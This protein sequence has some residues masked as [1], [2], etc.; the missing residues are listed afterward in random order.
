MA[1]PAHPP[2]II[3][4]GL[5]E[6]DAANGELRKAGVPVKIHPQPFRVL[7]LLAQRPGEVV[8]REEIRRSLWGDNTFVDFERGINFCVNQIRA[9][10][11]DD[12]EKPRFVET[13]PRR[14]YR[15]IASVSNQLLVDSTHARVSVEISSLPRRDADEPG[16]G[17]PRLP[18]LR[19]VPKPRKV[20]QRLKSAYVGAVSLAGI[21]GLAF[22]YYWFIRRLPLSLRKPEATQLTANSS[23]NPVTSSAISPDGKYLAFTDHMKK[24]R[25]RLLKTGETRT[26]PE[27]E[28]LKGSFVDWHVASW[29]PDGTRFLVNASTSKTVAKSPGSKHFNPPVTPVAQESSIWSVSLLGGA[30]GK[31]RDDA[32][33]YSVSPDGS[34]IAFETNA[35]ELGTR[36]IRLMNVNG[37]QERMLCETDR[38]STI[39][40]ITWSRDGRRVI[41][42]SFNSLQSAII[43]HD[44]QGGAP[45]T[46]ASFSRPNDLIDSI[47]SPDGRLIYVLA[48][49]SSH[50]SCNFWELAVNSDTGRATGK[51]RQLSNWSGSCIGQ[52]SMTTDGKQLAFHRW[53]RQTAVYVAD[54][55]GSGMVAGSMRRLTRSE[56]VNAAETW[57]PD[58]KALVFRSLRDGHLKIFRQALDSDTEEMLVVGAE[59]AGGTSISPDGSWLFYLDCGKKWDCEHTVPLMRIPISGGTPQLVLQSNTYGRPRCAVSPATLCAIAESSDDGKS[60]IFTAFDALKGRGQEL[61]RFETDPA[62]TYSWGLSLDGTRIAILKDG[63]RRIHT[64]SLNGQPPRQTEVN[65]WDHLRGVYWAADGKGF[66]TC[67]LGPAGSVLLHTDMQGKAKPLWQ[68]EGN[69]STYALPSPDGRHLAIVGTSRTNNVWMIENF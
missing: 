31:L 62:A 24:I 1:S 5:F 59:N 58:G 50:Y 53:A 55:S 13:A 34:L 46:I 52:T 61:T 40:G 9:T 17:V 68:Q 32:E 3:R 8:A 67:A 44:L 48:D 69:T 41:Y 47:W 43:S 65:G 35:T 25:M 7:L 21:V 26:V 20:T 27:P 42:F 18:E 38:N 60:L 36:E 63:D 23:E 16:P 45:T 30:P 22:G 49:D 66:F 33:A 6:L 11:G 4:F 39:G 14:G 2:S 10:L 56:Y 64:L 12:A 37:G 15:F 28:S 54:A 57:T 51:P 29:F 19:I